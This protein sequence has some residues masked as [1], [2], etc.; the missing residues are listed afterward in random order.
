MSGP[1]DRDGEVPRLP[2]GPLLRLSAP[3]LFRIGMIAIVLV[4]VIALRRPCADGVASFVTTMDAPDAGPP[5]AMQLERLTEEDI[6]R[7]F[8][9]PGADAGSASGPPPAYLPAE[10]PEPLPGSRLR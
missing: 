10:N 3:A 6:K 5:P 4:A 8:P 2:R 1:A 7:R 9:G